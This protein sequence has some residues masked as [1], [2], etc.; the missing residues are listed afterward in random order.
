MSK[1]TVGPIG[2]KTQLVENARLLAMVFGPVPKLAAVAPHLAETSLVV[3]TL[4]LFLGC[5]WLG[6]FGVAVHALC[7]LL[8][9]VAIFL[10]EFANG[11]LVLYV[12][13]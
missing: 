2:T 5:A 9:A 10:E 3:W 8:M 11:Y 6:L 12:H 1:L 13:V 7:I 4:L